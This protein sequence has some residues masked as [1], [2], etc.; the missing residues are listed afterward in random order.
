[1]RPRPKD[2]PFQGSNPIDH[3]LFRA[4]TIIPHSVHHTGHIKIVWGQMFPNNHIHVSEHDHHEH[5]QSSAVPM[6]RFS[7][8]CSFTVPAGYA[9]NDYVLPTTKDETQKWEIILALSHPEWTADKRPE[10]EEERDRIKALVQDA[11]RWA[12]ELLQDRQEIT[13]DLAG[14]KVVKTLWDGQ[15]HTHEVELQGSGKRLVRLSKNNRIKTIFDDTNTSQESSAGP[16][17]WFNSSLPSVSSPIAPISS[18]IPVDSSPGPRQAPAEASASA[19]RAEPELAPSPANGSNLK[20]GENGSSSRFRPLLSHKPPSLNAITSRPAVPAQSPTLNTTNGQGQGAPMKRKASSSSINGTTSNKLDFDQ[21]KRASDGAQDSAQGDVPNKRSAV[22]LGPPGW[23]LMLKGS[24]AQH[25]VE[26]PI[27][28]GSSTNGMAQRP[29]GPTRPQEEDEQMESFDGSPIEPPDSA[30]SQPDISAR[31]TLA[32]ET[33]ICPV[34]PPAFA[35]PVEVPVPVPATRTRL[36]VTQSSPM[37]PSHTPSAQPLSGAQSSPIFPSHRSSARSTNA[38]PSRSVTS[39]GADAHVPR[40]HPTW[41]NRKE[42]EAQIRAS[43]TAQHAE[44]SRAAQRRAANIE[45]LRQPFIVNGV[46]YTPLGQIR[47]DTTINVVCIV[48]ESKPVNSPKGAGRDYT[49]SIVVADPS[50]HPFEDQEGFSEELMV[51]TLFRPKASDLPQDLVPGNAILIRGVKATL[52]NNKI[53]GQCFHQTGGRVASAWVIMNVD[54]KMKGIHGSDLDPPLD[55][56]EVDRMTQTLD[57]WQEMTASSG[58]SGGQR[59]MSSGFA[60]SGS[61]MGRRTSMDTSRPDMTLGSVGRGDFFNAT[62]KVLWVNVNMTRKPA[63]EV[64]VTDGTVSSSSLRNFHNVTYPSIPPRA[65]F[66]L[67]IFDEPPESERPLLEH[68]NILR[69]HNVR[70]KDF[71]GELELSWSEKVTGEQLDRGWSVR[72]KLCLVEKNDERAKMIERRLK[73]LERGEPLDDDGDAGTALN[74]ATRRDSL[75]TN[76]TDRRLSNHSGNMAR[77]DAAPLIGSASRPQLAT[78]VGTI[79]RDPV[80][81]PVSTIAQIHSNRTLPNKYRIHAR[82]KSLH[83]RSIAGSDSFVQPYCKHCR[84]TFKSGW[85]FCKSCNDEEGRKAEWRYRFIAILEEV[86]ED[87]MAGD[88]TAV[89]IADNEAAEFLPALPPYSTTTNPNE[90]A[91]TNQRRSDITGQVYNILQGCKMDNVRPKPVIDFSL[92][93]YRLDKPMP[94]PGR[95][96]SRNGSRARSRSESA[97]VGVGVGVGVAAARAGGNERSKPEGE[98]V[99]V[100]KVFG[101]KCTS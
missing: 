16:P 74:A 13:V 61:P 49:M 3:T 48:A 27:K 17:A 43:R 1:M 29:S 41:Q 32:H 69:M 66:C 93:V 79:Y 98:S 60:G 80:S 6:L 47:R 88:Q 63:L 77:T 5:D 19:K 24:A 65:I 73:Q 101:M 94:R 15:T 90:I 22:H 51:I 44:S 50:R 76:N 9:K 11:I 92:M 53:K 36:G 23:E 14:L 31:T 82:V 7:F 26:K 91:R 28:F 46:S 52:Y 71:N 45:L 78:H 18:A 34:V 4:N 25:Q 54:K 30:P 64:Y 67:A 83:S 96:V 81:H 62:F 35:P 56:L 40:D 39:D 87:G 59:R 85:T 100:L 42:I 99:V 20:H 38:V 75:T 37:L 68:G 21:T 86:N 95:S 55:S 8:R 2:D 10:S 89:I 57:W 84:A 70:C 33:K 12:N 97:G 72:R 58:E